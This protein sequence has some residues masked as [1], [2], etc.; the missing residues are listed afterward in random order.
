MSR[1]V[2]WKWTLPMA[3]NFVLELPKSAK[4]TSFQLQYGLP[5]IWAVVSFPD[6][7]ELELERRRFGLLGTG[8]IVDFQAH[9]LSLT[10]PRDQLE[11]YNKNKEKI[12]AQF[13]TR[14]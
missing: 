2:V 11:F 3:G 8:N 7:G 4:I 9:L 1:S 6:S 10:D 14:R 5:S 12:H 13:G